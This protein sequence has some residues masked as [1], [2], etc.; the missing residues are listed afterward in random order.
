MLAAGYGVC[1]GRGRRPPDCVR[2]QALANV[3]A[4]LL[5]PRH[6]LAE[7]GLGRLTVALLHLVEDR[8][9]RLRL[10]LLPE[11]DPLVD[12]AWQGPWRRQ[13]PRVGWT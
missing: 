13:A 6:L 3:L 5:C 11:R 9:R 8:D 12:Q 4:E 2:K 1:Q 7:L 10:P